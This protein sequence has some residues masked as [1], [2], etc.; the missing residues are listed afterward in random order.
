MYDMNIFY[1][2]VHNIAKS[3]SNMYMHMYK[4]ICMH[5]EGPNGFKQETHCWLY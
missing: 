3:L 2:M 4:I 5:E 1:F